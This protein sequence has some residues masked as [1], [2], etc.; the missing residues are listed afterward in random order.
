[1]KI[2]PSA[3]HKRFKRNDF[4]EEEKKMLQLAADLGAAARKTSER[5]ALNCITPHP[6]DAR[7][8]AGD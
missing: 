3:I 5:I 1:M 8:R 4:T 6:P 2:K 7:S